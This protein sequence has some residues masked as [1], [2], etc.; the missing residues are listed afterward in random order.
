MTASLQQLAVTPIASPSPAAKA[1]KATAGPPAKA[2]RSASGRRQPPSHKD[3]ADRKRRSRQTKASNAPAPSSRPTAS[4]RGQTTSSRSGRGRVSKRLLRDAPYEQPP[5]INTAQL[6]RST[7]EGFTHYLID[8]HPWARY[9]NPRPISML[10]ERTPRVISELDTDSYRQLPDSGYM[11]LSFNRSLFPQ[12]TLRE[13]HP[14]AEITFVELPH[15][16]YTI[17]FREKSKRVIDDFLSCTYQDVEVADMD[18]T[19]P[20]NNPSTIKPPVIDGCHPVL[21]QV[22][23]AGRG[24]G[25]V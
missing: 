1:S 20:R 22:V 14:S 6:P 2:R 16:E 3:R 12:V 15:L 18:P 8:Y 21:Y 13:N 24:I 17:M 5:Q 11:S 9:V 23:A 4:S 7:P 10:R 19:P 25:V